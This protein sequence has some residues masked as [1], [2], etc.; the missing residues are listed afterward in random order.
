MKLTRKDFECVGQVA[1]HCDE[2]KLNIAICEASDNDLYNLFCDTWAD[3]EQWN[4]EV[5]EYRKLLAE[6][7]KCVE[8]GGEDCEVPLIP[9]NYEEKVLL[10][11][12]GT[13]ENCNGK[14]KMF[15][16]VKNILANYAYARYL[17][18]NEFNDTPVGNKVK[19]NDFSMPKSLKELENFADKYRSI[20]YTEFE[21]TIGYMCYEKEVFNFSHK[22]CKGCSCGN[23]EGH[24]EN[25][26][27]GLKMKNISK[28]L[29]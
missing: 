2:T 10:L 17:L 20:G 13:Y 3:I 16:G 27:Y 21:R 28:R 4:D 1:M 11:Y 19:T 18:I 29:K 23:C 5:T 25:K 7:E 12:G 14:K 9:E 15:K 8:S 24:T 26:G 22:L 6:Y